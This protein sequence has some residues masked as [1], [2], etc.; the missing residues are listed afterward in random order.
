[1]PQITNSQLLTSLGRLEERVKHL[2]DQAKSNDI[3]HDRMESKIEMLGE[4]IT[5]LE[6]NIVFWQRIGG[7]VSPIVAGVLIVVIQHLFHL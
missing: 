6:T 3:S 4:K 1:M 7:F 2:E 5:S